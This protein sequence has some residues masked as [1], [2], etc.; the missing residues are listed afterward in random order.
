MPDA[1]TIVS[2]PSR[3]YAIVRADAS[4]ATVDPVGA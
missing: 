4:A 2:P 3:D 1:P